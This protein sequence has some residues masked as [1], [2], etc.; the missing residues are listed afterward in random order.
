MHRHCFIQTSDFA[1]KPNHYTHPFSHAHTYTH[2]SLSLYDRVWG[3]CRTIPL[4]VWHRQNWNVVFPQLSLEHKGEMEDLAKHSTYIAGFLDPS[5]QGRTD[6][7]DLLING[8]TLQCL[9][10]TLIHMFVVIISSS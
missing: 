2:V 4:F 5:V 9:V 1:S 10:Y 8:E 3:E 7:Y 6:L